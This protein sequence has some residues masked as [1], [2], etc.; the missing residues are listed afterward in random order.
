ML[1][2]RLWTLH[3]VYTANVTLLNVARS[4][5]TW[6]TATTVSTR[7]T[8]SFG[9]SRRSTAVQGVRSP[10]RNAVRAQPESVTSHRSHTSAHVQPADPRSRLTR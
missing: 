9:L 4:M 2:N 1:S 7:T 10:P 3:R 6:A 8:P 5:L